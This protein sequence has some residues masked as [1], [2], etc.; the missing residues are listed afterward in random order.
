MCNV[1]DNPDFWFPAEKEV[2]QGLASS[3]FLAGKNCE[4]VSQKTPLYDTIPAEKGKPAMK[5][6]VQCYATLLGTGISYR[7]IREI[8]AAVDYPSP[9]ESVRS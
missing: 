3:V 1:C 7:E 8:F 9:S 5:A 6:N 2:I 4:Y